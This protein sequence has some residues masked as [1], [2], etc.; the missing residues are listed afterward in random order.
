MRMGA[1]GRTPEASDAVVAPAGIT[2]VFGTPRVASV[3]EEHT[4]IDVPVHGATL[5]GLPVAHLSTYWGHENGIGGMQ[6]HFASPRADLE[7]A[8]GGRLRAG[9]VAQPSVLPALA[10]DGHAV[11][12]CDWSM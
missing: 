3:A 11:L 7:D 1:D 6:M 2:G 10:P 9:A 8:V 5:F 4:T 12:S